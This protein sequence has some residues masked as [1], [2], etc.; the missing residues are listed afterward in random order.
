MIAL[1]LESPLGSGLNRAGSSPPSPVLERPPKRFMA[2]AKFSCAPLEIEPK[3]M[4]PV[5]KRLK[6][7]SAGSTFSIGIGL[8]ALNF[9]RL[10]KVAG[11]LDWSL[12][13]SENSRY[14]L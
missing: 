4:A 14:F 10:L 1:L 11:F 3:L 6:I 8:T 7:F 9:S 2:I 12:I 13:R 5:A